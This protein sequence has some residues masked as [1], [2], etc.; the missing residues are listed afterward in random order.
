MNIMKRWDKLREKIQDPKF[1]SDEGLG[2]E[3]NIHIFCYDPKDE[4][5]VRY[6]TEQLLSD[7]T[8]HSN[9]IEKNLYKI[10]LGICEKKKVLEKIPSMEERK[11]KNFLLEKIKGFANNLAFADA[12]SVETQKSGDILLITGIGEVFPFVRLHSVL[13]ALQQK[14]VER[15]PIVALYPG[16]YNGREV[17]LFNKLDPKGYY[18]AFNIIEREK[19]R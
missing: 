12:I 4:M 3:V 6:F 16:D 13:D 14:N 7:K 5:A 19:I 1:F 2:G 18:R 10:F 11:G 17:I 9:V 8:L 15:I